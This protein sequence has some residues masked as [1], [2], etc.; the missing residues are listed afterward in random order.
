MLNSRN[1][2][3]L[4]PDVAANCKQFLKVC[5]ARGLKVLVTNTVRDDEYQAYLYAQGRTRPGNLV[6]NAKKP[7]FHSDKAG[8]AFDICKN[9]KGQEY[10]DKAFFYACADIGKSMG[11]EWGGDWK[12]LVDMP[13]F[14]WSG[15]NHEFTGGDVLAGRYPPAMPPV[16]KEAEKMNFE[17]A[18][19]ILAK[20]GV[21]NSPEY[22]EK[23][24]G[25]VMYFRELVVK[26]AK[27]LE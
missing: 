18:L 11:F 14:Q 23:V 1:I 15:P 25:C 21:I 19:E 6:T 17:E 4:R 16:Q 26:I 7:S 13:H 22:W 20:K 2:D 10:S 27:E 9:Q 5:A 3:H 24:G 8:L 12:S